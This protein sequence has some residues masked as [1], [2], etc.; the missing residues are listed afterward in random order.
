MMTLIQGNL[1]LSANLN[2]ICISFNEC[3]CIPQKPV[4]YPNT[5]VYAASVGVTI[6]TYL[7]QGS[8]GVWMGSAQV[9]S[10]V[11]HFTEF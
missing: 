4:L 6:K 8:R 10:Q 5:R 1:S 3:E 2:N 7:W 11:E 9:N